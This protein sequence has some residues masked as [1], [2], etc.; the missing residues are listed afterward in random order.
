MQMRQC[1]V[2]SMGQSVL[3]KPDT[4][5]STVTIATQIYQLSG[6]RKQIASEINNLSFFCSKIMQKQRKKYLE[7]MHG[8]RKFFSEGGRLFF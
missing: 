8:S 5:Q 4:G 7:V 1:H 6:D 3:I 2:T